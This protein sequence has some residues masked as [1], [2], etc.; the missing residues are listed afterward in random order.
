MPHPR[1]ALPLVLALAPLFAA[2]LARAD[3]P[4]F[5]TQRD[6]SPPDYGSYESTDSR[7]SIATNGSD[8]LI[9]WEGRNAA[10]NDTVYC[11]RFTAGGVL[12][13]QDAIGLGVPAG[14]PKAYWDGSKYLVV[15]GNSAQR[16]DPATGATEAPLPTWG[17]FNSPEPLLAHAF[18][19][20]VIFQA[21][22]YGPN[23]DITLVTEKGV[24]W[25]APPLLPQTAAS[26][27]AGYANGMFLFAWTNGSVVEAVRYSKNGDL[28]DKTPIVIDGGNSLGVDGGAGDGGAPA[29]VSSISV[30][31]SPSGFLVT[32]S[33]QR[34]GGNDVYAARVGTDAS[35][36][37]PGGRLIATN[38]I[39]GQSTATWTGT[40]WWLAWETHATLPAYTVLGT[41]LEPNG[42][43]GPVTSIANASS[44]YPGPP[45]LAANAT[46]LLAAYD[47]LGAIEG[48]LFDA[49]HSLIGNAGTP[50]SSHL[51]WQRGLRLATSSAGYMVT[52]LEMVPDAVGNIA[53]QG[54]AMRLAPDGSAIDTTPIPTF[55]TGLG[56]V[57]YGALATAYAAAY[58]D[59]GIQIEMLDTTGATPAFKKVAT[60]PT[61]TG[62]YNV[63]MLAMSCM[64]DRCVVVWYDNNA[65]NTYPAFATV[66]KADGTTTPPVSV[67]SADQASA[68]NDG[69]SF[70]VVTNY[71]ARMYPIA[72]D[73]TV[74]AGMNSLTPGPLV[75]GGDRYLFLSW[76][77]GSNT[78]ERLTSAG[79]PIGA[80]ETAPSFAQGY[81]VAQAGWD[82]RSFV[83]FQGAT[84]AEVPATAPST[85]LQTFSFFDKATPARVGSAKPQSGLVLGAEPRGGSGAPRAVVRMIGFDADGGAGDG[86]TIEAGVED[87]GSEA[88]VGP[89]DSGSEAGSGEGG[90]VAE[91]G[92]PDDGG[93]ADG[94]SDA[95]TSAD[96]SGSD[97]GSSDASD[98]SSVAQDAGLDMDATVLADAGVDAAQPPSRMD[99]GSMD[100]AMAN[101]A[102]PVNETGGAGN[103]SGC[104][105]SEAGTGGSTS[106]PIGALLAMVGVVFVRRRRRAVL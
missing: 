91:A 10:E 96:A 94:G 44:H 84:A 24:I 73:G 19:D 57:T 46:T 58:V 63:E 18:G 22:P 60:V 72:A 40:N 39:D 42:T 105:C 68:G 99:A 83:V 81:L 79:A 52:W 97:A 76:G 48:S 23:V 106:T 69:S 6:V 65:A 100:A 4:V 21:Y 67:G 3:I 102:G 13:D 11:A 62:G 15:A 87:G 27:G 33:D 1:R 16:V 95:T 61:N 89:I 49:S 25:A 45:A 82:G 12:L 8:F 32:W 43:Q 93:A 55:R 90:L 17:F 7:A 70:L 64:S 88:G 29:S 98:D 66:V 101:E 74:G 2:P 38:T 28:E 80:Q 50:L 71:P 5:G 53:Y 37:D 92:T 78:L 30:A 54:S 103:A 36:A 59:H 77:G 86:G 104:G 75:W 14:P 26:V 34:N 47:G 20:G 31:S 85:G 35:V 51:A 41:T 9:A 56:S